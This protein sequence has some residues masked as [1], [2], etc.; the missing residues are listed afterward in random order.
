MAGQILA[1]TGICTPVLQLKGGLSMGH[2]NMEQIFNRRDQ[3]R[4]IKDVW[5]V[6]PV[7]QRSFVQQKSLCF[8]G[9]NDPQYLILLVSI[10]VFLTACIKVYLNRSKKEGY[11][12]LKILAVI[13]YM[14][15]FSTRL[16]EVVVQILQLDS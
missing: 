8:T 13:D 14:H 10:S 4:L 6:S 9:V 11:L 2:L 5:W 15:L 12:I 3:K 16:T 7:A 1:G